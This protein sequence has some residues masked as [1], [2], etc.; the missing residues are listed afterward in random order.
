MSEQTIR[1]IKEA[2]GF[3]RPGTANFRNPS[4]RSIF[5]G[6]IRKL[7]AILA[8][9]LLE[10]LITGVV[11]RPKNTTNPRNLLI[12]IQDQTKYDKVLDSFLT[13]NGATQE[14]SIGDSAFSAETVISSDKKLDG[15]IVNLM[16]SGKKEFQDLLNEYVNNKVDFELLDDDGP[17]MSIG[18]NNFTFVSKY[19]PN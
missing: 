8:S 1:K 14:V 10:E 6:R 12:T 4:T 5:E 7:E 2:R 17:T 16:I 13:S 9:Q 18:N 11:K 19:I 3:I 15:N